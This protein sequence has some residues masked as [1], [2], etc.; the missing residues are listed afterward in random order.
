ML[1]LYA[2]YDSNSKLE[3]K[4][5]GVSTDSQINIAVNLL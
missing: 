2:P 3:D 4:E 5:V 1:V